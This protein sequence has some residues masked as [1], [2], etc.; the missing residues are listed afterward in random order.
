MKKI[1]ITIEGKE[2]ETIMENLLEEIEAQ[3][4]TSAVG[5]LTFI[6]YE[7]IKDEL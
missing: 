6:T 4:R 5:Y 2:E 3:A 1:L 7:E